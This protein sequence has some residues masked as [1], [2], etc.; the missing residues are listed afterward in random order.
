MH[1][2]V[3]SLLP[4]VIVIPVAMWTRQVI[5]GLAVGLL[6]GAF[7]LHPSPVGGLMGTLDYLVRELAV[8]GNLRLILFLYGFGALVGLVRT[9]GGV[10]GFAMWL[11]K[12]IR[13][14]RGAFVVTWLSGLATFMAPD[15][16]IITVAPIMK[17]VFTRLKVPT[18]RVAVV[19]DITATPLSAVV[20]I[21]TAFVG[22][23]VGLLAV[24]N[25][26]HAL[27]TTPFRLFLES[28]PWNLF[29]WAAMLAGLWYTFWHRASAQRVERV[30]RRQ[31]QK[32][33]RVDGDDSDAQSRSRARGDIATGA[34][35]GSPASAIAA[36]RLATE[37]GE[38]LGSSEDGLG[39]L[40]AGKVAAK[41]N[42]DED[43]PDP[44][45]LVAE[46]S[47]PRA[48]NLLIP[49]ALLLCLTLFFTWWSGHA[50]APGIF[51]ALAQA[52]ASTAMLEALIVTL[53][54]TV[55]LYSVKRQPIARTM[56]GFMSGGNEMMG[57]IVLLSLVWAVTAVS[58]DLGFVPF[59][60]RE[61][62]RIVPPAFIAP[63]LFACGCIISYV[64][65]SSFGTWAMLLP[66]GFSLAASTHASIPLVVGAVFASGTFGGFASPLSD[67]TVAM[68]TVMKLPI[69][70]YAKTK[71]MIALPVA[72]ACTVLYAVAGL[73]VA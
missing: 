15:F 20:P 45:E 6:A 28:I 65:G 40:D 66:L 17:S 2:S 35:T 49:L 50:K 16:R 5:P 41:A 70:S 48:S 12:R 54:V 33:S 72:G 18:K 37:Y 13:S 52:D 63:A 7:M 68:A 4:F 31:T 19:I 73:T 51:G 14:T 32:A 56:F 64:I 36:R 59:T 57:V 8:P 27:G 25:K 22:Y 58:A 62:S 9:S 10:A 29:A 39:G 60:E 1:G 34:S 11:E 44:V 47:A 55:L 26:Q 71:L 21:G 67:N 3:W 42:D 38:E 46:K 43:F 53:V 23:M 30:S 24:A 69:M 61:V